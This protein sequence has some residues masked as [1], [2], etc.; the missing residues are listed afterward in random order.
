M[1]TVHAFVRA[2]SLEPEMVLVPAVLQYQAQ[3]QGDSRMYYRGDSSSESQLAP[4]MLMTTLNYQLYRST[5][6]AKYAT[7]FLG[8]YDPTARVLSTAMPA[9]CHLSWCEQPAKPFPWTSTAPWSVYL[10]VSLMT[11]QPS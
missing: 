10:T 1:A 4:A 2:Y 5:P 7:M 11:N 9:T 6:A 3:S 8:C